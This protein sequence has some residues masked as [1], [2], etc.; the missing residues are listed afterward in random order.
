MLAHHHRALTIKVTHRTVAVLAVGVAVALAALL[1]A[2][3]GGP[4]GEPFTLAGTV[5]TDAG[6]P[7]AAATVAAT[8]VGQS[9]PIATATTTGTGVYGL[10]LPPA[11]YSVEASKA[12]FQPETRT[13]TIT[14]SQPDL[15]FDF[16]LSTPTE[17]PPPP[18]NLGGRVTN[19]VTS[20]PIGG[21]TVAATLQGETSPVALA[22]TNA[23]GRYYFWLETGTYVVRA[24]ATGYVS[25]E[26]EVALSLGTPNLAVDFA[27][28]P[29]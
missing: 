26:R 16:T 12:G 3:C 20:A 14:A 1:L 18:G 5:K 4:G 7:V 23:D 11:T 25:Q 24:S 29:S 9:Q 22:T 27:L 8:V 19:A 13:V 21:A 2:G 10:A 28:R 17:P 6:A 15:S